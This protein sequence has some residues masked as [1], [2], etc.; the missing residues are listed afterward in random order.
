MKLRITP[1]STLV[2]ALQKLDNS[3]Q[4]E[5][6]HHSVD[7]ADPLDDLAKTWWEE[8]AS[9]GSDVELKLAEIIMK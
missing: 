5:N 2:A 1:V 9:T 4:S 3:S 8:D 7:Y 6:K